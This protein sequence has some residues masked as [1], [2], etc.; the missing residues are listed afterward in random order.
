MTRTILRIDSS[1]K[2]PQSVSR[3]LTDKVI[4][5]LTADAPDA[6]VVTRDLAALPA[7][8]IDGGWLGAV[9]TDA[10]QRNADQTQ[11]AA[12]SDTLIDEVKAADTIVIGLPIY[13]FNMPAQ[14]KAWLD[15]LTRAGVTFRYT[16]NGPVGLV[17][18][19]RAIVVMTSDGTKMGSEIDFATPYLK[20][21]LGFIGITDVQF[22]AAD[23]MVHDREATLK[24][25]HEAVERLAA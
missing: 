7:P 3:Q 5:R 11:V 21:L 1:I 14:L 22:V 8:M 10:D 6:T 4:A 12:L 24:A 2:G 15:Q 19:T 25:A 13:N 9:F 23:A 17:E 16:E 18:N 20:H